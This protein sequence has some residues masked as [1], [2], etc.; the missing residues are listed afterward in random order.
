M[1]TL[2]EFLKSVGDFVDQIEKGGPGSGRH[3][4]ESAISEYR[5]LIGRYNQALTHFG[6]DPK[7]QEYVSRLKASWRSHIMDIAHSQASVIR[8]I[9]NKK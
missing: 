2:N 5:N 8:E 6:D 3:R 1:E 9:H 7:M 4:E